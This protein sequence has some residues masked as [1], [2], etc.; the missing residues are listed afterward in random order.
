[1]NA[2]NNESQTESSMTSVRGLQDR[3][4]GFVGDKFSIALTDQGGQ[5]VKSPGFVN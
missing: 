2:L 1:M 4:T 5:N 3:S